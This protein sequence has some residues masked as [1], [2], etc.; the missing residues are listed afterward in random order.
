M[1]LRRVVEHTLHL[2]KPILV[3]VYQ[4]VVQKDQRG[5]ACVAEQIGVGQPRDD[6]EL[7][8]GALAELVERA[9]LGAMRPPT[10]DGAGHQ[11]VGHLDLRAGEG[12]LQIVAQVA[13][14]GRTQALR[15]LGT[16]PAQQLQEVVQRIGAAL[17][18]LGTAPVHLGVTL[19]IG[20]LLFQA[21]RPAGLQLNFQPR[22]SLVARGV[23]LLLQ[24]RG[25]CVT[26]HILLQQR[27]VECPELVGQGPQAVVFGRLLGQAI[28]QPQ[29]GGL[30]ALRAKRVG[31]GGLCGRALLAR[32]RQA[33]LGT[34]SQ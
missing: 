23:G 16:M 13:L 21:Q 8:A 17:Q 15:E 7:F 11:V 33:A 2:S 12:H 22:E 25:R 18:L 30:E 14:Q 29:A 3:G 1:T 10:L 5:P 6:T 9:A 19:G 32:R 34:R 24:L 27:G 28:A 4:G 31:Q 26:L 20:L